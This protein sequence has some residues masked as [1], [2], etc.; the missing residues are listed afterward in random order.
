MKNAGQAKRAGVNPKNAPIAAA[1]T[2]WSK[3]RK[4]PLVAGVGAV[5]RRKNSPAGSIGSLKASAD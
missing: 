1:A 5:A 3:K 2:A 4:K